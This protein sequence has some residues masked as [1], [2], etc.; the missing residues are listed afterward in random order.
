[1]SGRNRSLRKKSAVS[2]DSDEEAQDEGP[3]IL[4]PAA[5]KQQQ[6]QRAAAKITKLSFEDD[7]GGEEGDA[8]KQKGSKP[9]GS[10]RAPSA[11]SPP[12]AGDERA[13][14]V[15]TQMASAGEEGLRAREGDQ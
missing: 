4:P 12:P 9:R 14:R 1:M 10:L 2:F 7:A 13:Q 3:G 15:Y 8:A 11:A 6:K 5:V